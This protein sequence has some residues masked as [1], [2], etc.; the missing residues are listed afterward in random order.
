L[1]GADVPTDRVLDG[2]D[3]SGRIR[4]H[5]ASPRDSVF[6]YRGDILYAVRSGPWKMH[7]RSRA[8]SG[9]KETIHETPLLY[10]LE[11]DPS[12]KKDLAKKHPE[13]IEQ[14]RAVAENHRASLEPVENQ[15]EK[16]IPKKKPNQD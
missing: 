10:H 2:A 9:A 16:V 5:S 6:F 15:M 14:L 4:G 12:E 11:H 8:R 3:I 1:A 7:F 13:V